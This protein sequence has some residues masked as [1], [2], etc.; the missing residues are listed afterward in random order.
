[1][2]R[3]SQRRDRTACKRLA[4][5]SEPKAESRQPKAHTRSRTQ[6]HTHRQLLTHIG[7]HLLPQAAKAAARLPIWR[8]RPANW[9]P[10][11]SHLEASLPPGAAATFAISANGPARASLYNCDVA[12]DRRRRV[13]CLR[14]WSALLSAPS[15]LAAAACCAK[16]VASAA[17]KPTA[18]RSRYLSPAV[19]QMLRAR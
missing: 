10:T 1:M 15:G 7:R 12:D 4:A 11:G 19:N 8:P 9:K 6:A 13:T 2:A 5:R 14:A 16:G 18:S 3:A 17:N